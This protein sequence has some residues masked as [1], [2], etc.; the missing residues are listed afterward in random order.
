V[1][2][3]KTFGIVALAALTAMTVLGA[4]SASAEST[5]LCSTHEE[6]CEVAN[7]V[8]GV[9]L[10]LVKGTVAQMLS[11]IATVLCLD[12]LI[13]GQSAEETLSDPLEL[14]VLLEFN[15]CGSNAAHSNCSIK[16]LE[17][18]GF[19]LLK[20]AL[21]LGELGGYSAQPGVVNVQ[22]TIIGFQVNCDLNAEEL[23]FP[24]EGA[25]HTEGAGNGMI[26]AHEVPT[27]A[28]EPLG[29]LEFACSESSEMDLLLEAL[30]PIYVTS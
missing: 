26:V 12:V 25:G 28:A 7:Q 20:T 18:P 15:G 5:A 4:G 22:C 3:A 6:P 24:V 19:L 30:D 29:G 1:R 11:G 17:K 21:N 27:G 2:L 14:D 23:G 13:E 8:E 16:V 10:E 9:H